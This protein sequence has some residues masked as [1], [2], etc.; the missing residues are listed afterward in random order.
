MLAP[1]PLLAQG[2][3]GDEGSVEVSAVGRSLMAIAE[4]VKAAALLVP[5]AVVAAWDT[6]SDDQSMAPLMGLSGAGL[7]VA[8]AL[9]AWFAH[10]GALSPAYDHQRLVM[11]GETVGL[12]RRLGCF[13][14]SLGIAALDYA[15]LLLWG[16]LVLATRSLQDFAAA[17][18]VQ[19]AGTVVAVAWCFALL[20]SRVGELRLNALTVALAALPGYY[21]LKGAV[22]LHAPSLGARAR[23]RV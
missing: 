22:V 23:A 17:E 19:F 14:L 8:S 20:R 10:P 3:L 11:S 6:D 5:V 7:L 1:S 15:G 16:A 9:L 2:F 13:W 12:V 4:A 18:A 21:L